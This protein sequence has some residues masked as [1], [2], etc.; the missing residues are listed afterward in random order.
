MSWK[1]TSPMNERLRFV[2]AMLEAEESFGELCERFGV[3]RKQ[4]YKWKERYE[5][6]GVQALADRSRA[7]HSHPDA[8][9]S[10][11]EQLLLAARKKHPRWGPRKLMV[12]V[13]RQHPRTVA[14]A[15][16]RLRP[17]RRTLCFC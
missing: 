9:S 8:V 5:T 3:S 2:A 17:A 10:D 11:V 7:P 1:E 13:R 15:D 4:G 6:G 12:I 14:G 16:D